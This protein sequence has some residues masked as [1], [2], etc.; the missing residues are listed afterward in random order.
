MAVVTVIDH[1]VKP[2]VHPDGDLTVIDSELGRI[3]D[4][5]HHRTRRHRL[6]EHLAH[7][8]GRVA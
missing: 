6:D 8:P 7:H 5:L 4:Q 2:H 3:S 1:G